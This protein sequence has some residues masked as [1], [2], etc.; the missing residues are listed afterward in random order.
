[1][2]SLADQVHETDMQKGQVRREELV[3]VVSVAVVLDLVRELTRVLSVSVVV[4]GVVSLRAKGV[5]RHP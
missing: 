2:L 4:E 3:L 1:L 5:R